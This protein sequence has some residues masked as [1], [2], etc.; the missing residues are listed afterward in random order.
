MHNN[1]NC[2][3]NSRIVPLLSPNQALLSKW[4][5]PKSNNK[6][7]IY[8]NNCSSFEVD[9]RMRIM[10]MSTGA[11]EVAVTPPHPYHHIDNI[12]SQPPHHTYHN[13]NIT[14]PT[15][16]LPLASLFIHNSDGRDISFEAFYEESTP[17]SPGGDELALFND[18]IVATQV[19]MSTVYRSIP[20]RYLCVF[21][22]YIPY[23]RCIYPAL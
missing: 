4:S 5:L 10:M 11:V 16:P 6:F 18:E 1:K 17:A 8:V 13:H 20:S 2:M 7:V 21:L 3:V 15:N 19:A 14:S 22:S 12:T 9:R 23:S